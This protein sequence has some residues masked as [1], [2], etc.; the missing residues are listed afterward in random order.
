M[1]FTSGR[2]SILSKKTLHVSGHATNNFS[3]EAFFFL[4]TNC[5]V[6]FGLIAFDNTV[7]IFDTFPDLF[8]QA[9]PFLSPPAA[10]RALSLSPSAYDDNL[11]LGLR[12]AN[13]R[14]RMK[15]RSFYLASAVFTGR[16]RIELVLLYVYHYSYYLNH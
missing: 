4:I 10:I 7:A 5:L 12:Q 3:R 6:V 8:P 13:E 16:L 2:V 1:D 9:S 11:V 14:L 15:S